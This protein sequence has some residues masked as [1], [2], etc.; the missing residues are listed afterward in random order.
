MN[1]D[2]NKMA[3]EAEAALGAGAAAEG[4]ADPGA[5]KVLAEPVPQVT[6][7]Q[8]VA[9]AIIVSRVLFC[10]MTQLESPA[11]TLSNDVA[12]ELGNLW[13]PVCDKYGF[14]LAEIFGDYTLEFTAVMA[15]IAIVTQVRAAAKAEI[16]ARKASEPKPE[17]AAA[18]GTQA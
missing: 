10:K 14:N 7:A 4:G 3:A 17:P 8:A 11:K 18:D 5:E 9:G 12:M 13:G 15:T 2:F 6:N 16:D 1:T